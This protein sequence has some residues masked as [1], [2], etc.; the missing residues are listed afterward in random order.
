M[1]CETEPQHI[2]GARTTA[3][4]AAEGRLKV[5]EKRKII[6]KKLNKYKK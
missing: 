6:K 4:S 1:A 3:D 2:M 5:G